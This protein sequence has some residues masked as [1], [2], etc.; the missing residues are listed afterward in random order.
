[1][2]SSGVPALTGNYLVDMLHR[3]GLSSDSEIFVA[4]EQ[5]HIPLWGFTD[6]DTGD[7]LGTPPFPLITIPPSAF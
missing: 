7:L 3:D 6:L 1:M 5:Q 2:H 4:H